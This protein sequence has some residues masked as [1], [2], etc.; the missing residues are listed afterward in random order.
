[1]RRISKGKRAHLLHVAWVNET[2][3]GMMRAL[4][5]P[6]LTVPRIR[7][8]HQ[9]GDGSGATWHTLREDGSYEVS[10]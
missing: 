4:R 9:S 10:P 3:Q 6:M 7:I 8:V 2:T 5:A 1:M